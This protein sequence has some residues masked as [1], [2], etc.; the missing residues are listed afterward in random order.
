MG[1][2]VGEYF[3]KISIQNKIT[4]P[5][6]FVKECDS[7]EFIIKKDDF[8]DC[9]VVFPREN[10]K[11]HLTFIKAK[12]NEDLTNNTLQNYFRTF[13]RNTYNARLI[14][15]SSRITIPPPFLDLFNKEK[16]VVLVGLDHKFEIWPKSRFDEM[17]KNEKA[18]DDRFSEII[19]KL[20]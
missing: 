13:M 20:P 18:L 5:Q 4:I 6:Q 16:E 11:E 2:L 3:M 12:L 14:K 9:L 10:W 19:R 15:H 8:M 1:I 17:E 7:D